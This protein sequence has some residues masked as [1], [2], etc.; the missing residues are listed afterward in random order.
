MSEAEGAK[1]RP[2]RKG[3]WRGPFALLVSAFV[4][5]VAGSGWLALYP[6][7]PVDLGGVPNLDARA[8]RLRIPVGA[9][10]HL[11]G[12]LL[13]GRRETLIVVFHGYARDHTRAWRYAQFLNR[14]GYSVLTADFRSSRATHRLPT[15]VGAYEL[16]DARAEL[17][18]VSDHPALATRG[19]AL[20]G[21]SLG[22]SVALRLASERP[23]VRAVV[24]DCPFADGRRA[25]EG[26]L[27]RQ[28][29][30]PRE[31]FATLARGFGEAITGVDPYA[32]DAVAACSLLRDRPIFFIHSVHD[33]RFG[34][35]QSEDLW[36]A[37]GAKDSLWIVPDGGHTEA[38]LHHR[39]EYERR[40][41]AFLNRA[42]APGAK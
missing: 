37:A 11:D 22:G 4:V 25:I 33:N 38:W 39:V 41:T 28:W 3:G 17:D 1:V 27:Q 9:G 15:T 7:V 23:E 31:P 2:G 14:V 35:D 40:V 29:H 36:R 12:W 34:T 19:V 5:L 13:R 26:S 30:L 8:E 10:D 21:E 24:V 42:L 32:L 16:E 6:P 18:W 20:F